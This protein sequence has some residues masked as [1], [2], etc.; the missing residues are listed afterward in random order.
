[1]YTMNTL[2]SFSTILVAVI[3]VLASCKKNTIAVNPTNSTINNNPPGA[4]T[5]T[6]SDYSSDTAK[7][8]WTRAVDPD[9]DSVTYKIYLND[10]LKAQDLKELN[11]TFRNLAELKSYD[12]KVV[13]VDSKLKETPSSMNFTTKKYWL[14][15]FQKLEYGSISGYSSQGCGRMIKSNDGGYVIIGKTELL[16][17][18]IIKF[19]VIKIDSLGNENWKKYYDYDTRNSDFLRI[20][21]TT[22][23]YVLSAANQIIKIDNN[24]NLLWQKDSADSSLIKGTA[25]DD[26]GNIYTVGNVYNTALYK[27]EASFCKYNQHGEHLWSKNISYSVR[28]EFIDI[29]VIDNNDLIILGATG[30][31][32]A[33]FLVVKSDSEGNIF[34]HKIYPDNG[35]AFPENIIRTSEGNFVF[36]GFSL[37]AYV[38]P[39]FYLQMIDPN[40]N[41]LWN[42]YVNDNNT[43]GYSVAETND[44]NLIITGGYQL[45]YTAQSALYKFDKNG[46]KLWEKLYAEFNTQLFNKTV[47]P[48]S[49]G[50]YIIN[51]QK[52]KA[53]NTPPETDQIYIFKTDDKGEFN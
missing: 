43:K 13:A 2:K 50:G 52:S 7:I 49:D 32:D 47:I 29:K 33:D 23:G 12:V 35:Y 8:N 51:V 44:N 4:F 53:Y 16:N 15:F 22:N 31:P 37:G 42:Y 48:T 21:S 3:F 5:I 28:D 9:N 30:D 40:G 19:V 46:N 39:Y 38:I 41:N 27:V 26:F 25:T 11:Y 24:G 14:K 6:I 1:M 17:S 34:W 36:T 18:N 10:T 45:T 20:T